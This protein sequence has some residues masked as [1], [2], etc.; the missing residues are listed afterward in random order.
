[1]LPV[2][3]FIFRPLPCASRYA[4][5]AS[6]DGGP[7][8]HAGDGAARLS[9]LGTGGV[10]MRIPL[11]IVLAASLSACGMLAVKEQ[12]AKLDANCRIGGRVDA[13]RVD[14]APLIVVL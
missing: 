14:A 3:S 1:M 2:Q 6:R 8:S 9:C 10:P 5:R 12:Q 13:E 4:G 11:C 7:K